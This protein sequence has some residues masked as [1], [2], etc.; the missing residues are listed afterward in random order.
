VAIDSPAAKPCPFNI[1]GFILKEFHN[2]HR[3]CGFVFFAD[4]TKRLLFD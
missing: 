4:A 2:P 1:T 3:G